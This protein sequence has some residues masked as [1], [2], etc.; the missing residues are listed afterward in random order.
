MSQGVSLISSGFSLI[1]KKWGG[2][3]RGGSYLIIGPRKSG[4]TL[5]SLQFALE[6]TKANEVCLYFTN[7]RPKDL[8]IQAASL[9]FDIQ[10]YMN[11]NLL[12]VVRIAPPNEIYEV[13]NP[14]DY[15]IETLT[16]PS[17]QASKGA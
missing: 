8:M 11:Q 17:K 12:I 1:D 6:T 10:S 9:N 7:M 15:L 16:G 5:L 3:Y 13:P 2:I 14:D 4:R